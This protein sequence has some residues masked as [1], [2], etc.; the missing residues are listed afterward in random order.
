MSNV[1]A[2][3]FRRSVN[4]E[5]DYEEPN[6]LA[7]YVV[8]PLVRETAS[9]LLTEL[10]RN[11]GERAFVVLGPYG[12]GKSAFALYLAS[13]LSGGRGR[14]RIAT[15]LG[16]TFAEVGNNPDLADQYFHSGLVPILVTAQRG[17]LSAA[18]LR[19]IS[20][21]SSRVGHQGGSTSLAGTTDFRGAGSGSKQILEEHD[22]VGL[23]EEFVANAVTDGA[24][25]C[26][27]VIDEGGRFLEAAADENT[28]DDM[29]LLQRLAEVAA[30]C[31]TGTLGLIVI[32]HQDF[33]AHASRLSQ[34]RQNDWSK[35][36]GRFATI[37]FMES[38]GNLVRLVAKAL[39]YS[40][41]KSLIDAYT[42]ALP[43]YPE[44]ANRISMLLPPSACVDS[45]TLRQ[46]LPLHPIVAVCLPFLFRL[47]AGQN[48]RSLFA[49]LGSAEPMGLRAFIQGGIAGMYTLDRLWDY[50]DLTMVPWL[51]RSRP[52]ALAIV[53]EALTRL[54]TSSGEIDIRLLKNISILQLLTGLLPFTVDSNLLSCA[55]CAP[56]EEVEAS[57][58]RLNKS[59][60][61][62]YREFRR[63]WQLWEGSDLDI[64]DLIEKER[65][66]V[67]AM[68]QYAQILMKHF[69]P[70][71]IVA[72]RHFHQTGTLRFLRTR[73]VSVEEA[74][75]ARASAKGDG[76]LLLIV[77][78]RLHVSEDLE[79]RLSHRPERPMNERPVIAALPRHAQ[80]LLD[81][82]EDYLACEGVLSKERRLDSDAV[83]RRELQSRVHVSAELLR[84]NI[85]RSFNPDHDGNPVVRWFDGPSVHR[86]HGR[87]S[88]RASEIFDRTYVHCPII[89]N[90]LINRDALSST[91]ASARRELVTRLME[92]QNEPRLG[93]VGYPPEYCIYN[94]VIEYHRLVEH[95]D[96]GV[97]LV[98]PKEGA[99]LYPVWRTLD[100]AREELLRTSVV[101]ALQDLSDPP[102]GMRKAV[103]LLMLTVWLIQRQ[104]ELFLYEEGTFIPVLTSDILERLL[105]RPE[106]F[107]Y[108]FSQVSDANAVNTV[109]AQALRI[110]SSRRNVALHICKNITRAVREL[111][112]WAA[113]TSSVSPRTT[114]VRNAIRAARD[115]LRL[116]SIDLPIAV[117]LTGSSSRDV[118]KSQAN[119]FADRIVAALDELRHADER[120]LEEIE[121]ELA[122]AFSIS[123]VRRLYVDLASRM[124][125]L[126]GARIASPDVR[127][128][129]ATAPPKDLESDDDQAAWLSAVAT[130][131]VGKRPT[132]WTDVDAQQFRLTI[133]GL[134]RRFTAF[135]ELSLLSGTYSGSGGRMIHVSVLSSTGR[136]VTASHL[137]NE[138]DE[139]FVRDLVLSAKSFAEAQGRKLDA[140]AIGVI[141]ALVTYIDSPSGPNLRSSDE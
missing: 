15:I 98:S 71:P 12:T 124:R 46:V 55:T 99:P 126:V 35:V 110:S 137:L 50:L 7:G 25:G 42:S 101:S 79:L 70:S 61:V 111:S 30:R 125:A 47:Q 41:P 102:F 57:L 3:R 136:D 59:S 109:L 8:S 120:L 82:I 48:E 13:L 68:G 49:F 40:L 19:G 2:N 67:R 73:Y 119:E 44:L 83:A 134:A 76:D 91:V 117:E 95:M 131:V 77:P 75:D 4:L 18:I 81:A 31:S 65:E 22:P 138:S 118:L 36:R 127:R 69:P 20:G 87:L 90:E 88:E 16:E 1:P 11:D 80:S 27:L 89:R 54:S 53:D 78:S 72:S 122:D 106:T 92:R 43:N 103:A 135:E 104:D 26:L 17:P 113:S 14:Q 33:E 116:L 114:K 132:Q 121:T 100:R 133:W 129:L 6:A 58:Q 51:G 5:G 62:V 60:L 107:E 112:T 108:Q 9:H 74:L 139:T 52:R 94:S 10:G 93:F 39:S 130:A 141:D 128:L 56:I 140:V 85:R 115:P 23:L 29:F 123:P 37:P 28:F 105:A 21:A 34:Q 24:D 96:G 84:L 45:H 66:H 86:T 38:P 64:V 63:S 97:R 32:L